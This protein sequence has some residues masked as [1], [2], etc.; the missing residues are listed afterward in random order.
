MMG[1][2]VGWKQIP[3]SFIIWNKIIEKGFL[4]DYNKVGEFNE[5]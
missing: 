1:F 3:C 4:S 5:K 2:Q